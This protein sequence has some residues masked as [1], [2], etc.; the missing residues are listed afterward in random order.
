VNFWLA[1]QARGTYYVGMERLVG[2]MLVLE[3]G[4][5]RHL[6]AA[7]PNFSGTWV[8]DKEQ[9]EP[10]GTFAGPS[11]AELQPL[12]LDIVLS[13]RQQ[14]GVL[15]ISTTQDGRPVFEPSYR[16]GEQSTS[17]GPT[18]AVITSTAT[19]NSN[20][21]VTEDVARHSSMGRIRESKRM[22]EWSLS[23]DGKVLTVILTSYLQQGTKSRRDVYNRR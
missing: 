7:D 13:I 6:S 20:K 12:D 8:R 19:W 10:L 15:E 22:R 3:E 21:L 2:F 11:I 9:S 23:A 14:D 4:L 1:N 18:G 5:N 16:L 17:Y